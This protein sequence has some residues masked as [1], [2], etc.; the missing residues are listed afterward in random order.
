MSALPLTEPSYLPSR[1]RISLPLPRATCMYPS[2]AGHRVPRTAYR[3]PRTPTQRFGDA[4]SCRTPIVDSASPPSRYR[5]HTQPTP[6]GPVADYHRLAEIGILGEDD[7]VEL[8]DGQVAVMSPV[9]PRHAGCVG[10]LNRMLSRLVGDLG[11]VRVQ[12]PVVL[13]E[14]TEPAPDMVVARGRNHGYR[15]EHPRPEDVLL[16]IEVAESSLD[17]D[18]DLKIPLYAEAGVPEVWLVDLE[19]EQ[20]EVYRRPSPAGYRE[21]TRSGRGETVT[22]V[23]LPGFEIPI[24]SILG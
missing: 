13:G 3:R 12:N 4:A 17:L 1:R 14:H 22:A 5:R 16:L 18:R 23:N 8:L 7:R 15:R 24:S 20:V 19:A 9:R 2:R 10:A 21:M 6:Q 11:I